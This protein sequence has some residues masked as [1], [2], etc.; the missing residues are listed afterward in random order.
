MTNKRGS[1]R[2]GITCYP[3]YG[4]SGVVATELGKHL[5]TKGHEV[6]FIASDIPFRLHSFDGKFIFHEVKVVNYP[7][8]EYHQPYAL[9][10]AAIMSEVI[11]YQKLDI[12]H[13]HYAIPH[14]ISAYL[15]RQITKYP[16]KIITTLHGTD[17]TVV[18]NEPEFLPVTQFGIEESDGVTAV[19]KF[20]RD[21]TYKT[22]DIKNDIEVIYNFVDSPKEPRQSDSPLRIKYAPNGEK[23]ITHISNFRPVKRV[24]FIIEIF[25]KILKSMP[26]KLLLIGDGPD[27]GKAEKMC[28]E[29]GICDHTIFLG[30]HA[31][32]EHL[33]A[34]SD[35]SL[36]ASET[37]SFGL[38][39]LE[40]LNCGVPVISSRVGGVPEV[41]ENEKQ[42][43]LIELND[44]D[45]FAEAGIEI[46]KNDKLW[47]EMSQNGIKRARDFF[48]SSIIVPQYENYYRKVLDG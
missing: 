17:I 35:L 28:R 30:K 33:L 1:M 37:E 6:H 41:L 42:G 16:V 4:G 32:I 31:E 11:T 14:S 29:L 23:I 25:S 34:I 22:F 26:A 12:L 39:I 20:L 10:L 38:S 46:L 48:D 15:A 47:E 3:T 13:V 40:S 36:Y 27:R 45:G 21:E 7:L 43:F 9:N 5:A 2:I 19:S 24:E 18:G 44:I 8:F